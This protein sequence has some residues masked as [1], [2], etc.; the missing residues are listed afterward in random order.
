MLFLG[1]ERGGLLDLHF[2]LSSSALVFPV[3]YVRRK[4][5]AMAC[6]GVHVIFACFAKVLLSVLLLVIVL[7]LTFVSDLF[8]PH[9]LDLSGFSL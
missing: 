3:V 5:S 1:V 7:K 2:R 9:F 4:A 6:V 8:Q